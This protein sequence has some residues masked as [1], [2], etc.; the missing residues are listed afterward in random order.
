MQIF[1]Q[2]DGFKQTADLLELLATRSGIIFL[3]SWNKPMVWPFF[4]GDSAL[5]GRAYRQ[6]GSGT[7]SL[8][9]ASLYERLLLRAEI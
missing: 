4:T 5:H 1:K 9:L 8:L 3:K 7:C 6:T 2:I